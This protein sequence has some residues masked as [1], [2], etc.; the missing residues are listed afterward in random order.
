MFFVHQNSKVIACR[1]GNQRLEFFP[2]FMEEEHFLMKGGENDINVFLIRYF[3]H[4]FQVG[5]YFCIAGYFICLITKVVA[6]SHRPSVC[7]NNLYIRTFP[8]SLDDA[9]C[10]RAS[11]AGD[12]N[13]YCTHSKPSILF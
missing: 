4:R 8:E 5:V 13:I 7:A 6:C 3:M 11:D 12:Q 9:L 10:N 2:L 1:Q